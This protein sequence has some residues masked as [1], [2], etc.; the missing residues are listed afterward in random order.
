V[1]AFLDS[2]P[3]PAARKI[4]WVLRLIEELEAVPSCYLKKLES[5]ESLGECR[6]AFG[7]QAY[8]LLGFF[9]KGNVLVLTHGFQKKSRKIPLAEIQKTEAC[10]KD[11]IRRTTHHE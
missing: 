2:L 11:F 1:Q 5:A 3:G 4:T 8:R 6:A 9:R 10:R 7:A